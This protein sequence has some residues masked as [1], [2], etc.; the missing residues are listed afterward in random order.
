[1]LKKVVN[2][3][4]VNLAQ[5]LLRE[6]FVWYRAGKEAPMILDPFCVKIVFITIQ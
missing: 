5:S 4:L 3:A 1:M 6:L 2:I